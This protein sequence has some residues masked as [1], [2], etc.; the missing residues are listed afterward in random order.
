[1]EFGL[2]QIS[3]GI[4]R[5]FAKI[6]IFFSRHFSSEKPSKSSFSGASAKS[7]NRNLSITSDMD[8]Y[9]TLIH[10]YKGDSNHSSGS[11]LRC[12]RVPNTRLLES[13]IRL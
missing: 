6:Q 9:C 13:K 4:T 2:F 11:I 1:M 10:H 7:A 8:K 12:R 5:N 3:V